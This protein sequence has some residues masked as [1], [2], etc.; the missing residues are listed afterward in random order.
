VLFVV[1]EH[2]MQL[3]P[4]LQCQLPN[5]RLNRQDRR[6]PRSAIAARRQAKPIEAIVPKPMQCILDRK[7]AHLRHT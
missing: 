4:G 7:R 5:A 2:E 6:S 3:A 1:L